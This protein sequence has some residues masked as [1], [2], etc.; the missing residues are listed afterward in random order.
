M[1]RC[2]TGQ[3]Y[4]TK[5]RRRETRKGPEFA[6]R[7][8]KAFVG[9]NSDVIGAGSRQ[10]FFGEGELHVMDGIKESQLLSLSEAPSEGG[11]YKDGAL[12]YNVLSQDYDLHF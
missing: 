4:K 7:R 10:G 5:S 8:R 12:E 9:G 6:V 1:R 2:A 11:K 3:I